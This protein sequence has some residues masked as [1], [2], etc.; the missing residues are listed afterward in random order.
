MAF[1]ATKIAFLDFD[2]SADVQSL[3]FSDGALQIVANSTS[4]WASV[5]LSRDVALNVRDILNRELAR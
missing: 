4:C 3:G 5:I 2:G 1:K